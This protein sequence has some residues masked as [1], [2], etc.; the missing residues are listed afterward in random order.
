[1]TSQRLSNTL[2][3][4]SLLFWLDTALTGCLRPISR[5]DTC[6]CLASNDTWQILDA[7]HVGAKYSQSVDS[8]VEGKVPCKL[9]MSFGPTH[10]QTAATMACIYK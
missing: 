9:D 4:V 8:F 2:D 3:V 6:Y 1:M 5:S 7:T 10:S